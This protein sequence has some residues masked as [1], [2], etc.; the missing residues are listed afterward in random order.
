MTFELTIDESFPLKDDGRYIDIAVSVAA[1]W[2]RYNLQYPGKAPFELPA[3][4]E[5]DFYCRNKCTYPYL[6][7]AS[8]HRC[9]V[10]ALVAA[11]V[12]PGA[13]WKSVKGFVDSF[14]IDDGSPRAVVRVV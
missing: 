5:F 3:T 9:V 10:S 8:A 7:S 11:K 14:S 6:I 13:G 1:Q 12:L 2:S 4:I